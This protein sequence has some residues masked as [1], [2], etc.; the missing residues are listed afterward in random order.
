M[1]S[2]LAQ[3][4]RLPNSGIILGIPVTTGKDRQIVVERLAEGPRDACRRSFVWFGDPIQNF[5]ASYCYKTDYDFFAGGSRSH[6]PRSM[7]DCFYEMLH[8]LPNIRNF[9]LHTETQAECSLLQ[10]QWWSGEQ[11]RANQTARYP[12]YCTIPKL[13]RHK[14]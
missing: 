6:S 3:N 2:A 14:Q 5:A 13:M 7:L 4:G 12:S 9:A 1:L 8:V 11:I 10:S